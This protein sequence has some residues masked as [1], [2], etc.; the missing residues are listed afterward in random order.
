MGYSKKKRLVPAYTTL[1]RAVKGYG[2][3]RSQIRKRV[4]YRARVIERSF[5]LEETAA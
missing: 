4:L 5:G 3:P 1:C 2:G